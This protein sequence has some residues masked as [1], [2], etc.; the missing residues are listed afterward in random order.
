MSS[1]PTDRPF[2]HAS[3]L[4][5]AEKSLYGGQRVGDGNFASYGHYSKRMCPGDTPYTCLAD[6]IIAQIVWKSTQKVG[7]ASA[8][9]SQGRVFVVARYS[10]PGN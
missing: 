6:H 2:D 5:I 7:I 1:V 8:T 9:D 3:E 4:W 10:P